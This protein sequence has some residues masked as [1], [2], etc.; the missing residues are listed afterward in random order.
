MIDAQANKHA[1]VSLP[2]GDEVTSR[3]LSVS[4]SQGVIK[5]ETDVMNR[6]K[7]RGPTYNHQLLQGHPGVFISALLYKV[8]LQAGSCDH[9][10]MLQS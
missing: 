10:N 1:Y 5:G 6:R 7:K 4:A 2:G 9:Q 8:P 3:L